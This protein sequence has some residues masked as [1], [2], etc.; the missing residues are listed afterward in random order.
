MANGLLLLVGTS[1]LTALLFMPEI[2]RFFRRRRRQ[3][4]RRRARGFE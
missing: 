4:A 3:E 1:A 2:S